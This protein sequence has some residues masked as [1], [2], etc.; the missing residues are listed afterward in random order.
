MARQKLVT[1]V[2]VDVDSSEAALRVTQLGAGLALRVEDSANP[3]STPFVVDAS[4]NVGV[5]T[6]SPLVGLHVEGFDILQHTNANN[7]Y[8]QSIIMRKSRAGG[9]VSS[10]DSIGQIYFQAHDGTSFRD[11]AMIKSVVDATPGASDMPGRLMF[12]TTPDGSAS[13]AERMRIDNAGLITGT[14]TSLGAWT[15]YTPTVTANSGTFTTVAAL[16]RYCR[17]GKMVHCVIRISITDAGTAS[18]P[19]VT[20]PVAAINYV[21]QAASGFESGVTNKQVF[22]NIPAGASNMYIRMYDSSNAA[23][24]SYTLNLTFTYEAA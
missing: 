11:S 16:G 19:I 7:Q 22:G 2:S 14:G 17:I 10:G 4:G 12:Y 20:L 9:A 8:S 24:N 6:A 3:D 1:P 15:T 5:G 13:L 23:V 21:A 18:L